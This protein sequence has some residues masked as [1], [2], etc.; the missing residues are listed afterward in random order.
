VQQY[1]QLPR[2]RDHGSLLGILSSATGLLMEGVKSSTLSNHG[3]LEQL[4][5]SLVVLAAESAYYNSRRGNGLALPFSLLW[6]Q[7]AGCSQIKSASMRW[8][9]LW[10]TDVGE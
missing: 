9:T 3:N 6:Q 8:V 7:V 2:D 5:I 4:G 1:G 10:G